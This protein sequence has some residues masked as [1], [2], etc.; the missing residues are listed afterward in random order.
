MKAKHSEAMR[1]LQEE[2]ATLVRFDNELKELEEVI[3]A[4]KQAI[5]DAELQRKRL[6]HEAQAL[7][8]DKAAS[9]N[10]VANLEKMHEWINAEKQSVLPIILRQSLLRP[11]LGFLARL[12]QSL[13]STLRI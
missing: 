1:K 10:F 2:R 11:V 9:V 3:K 8:K 13:I 7:A 6:E 4:K 5:S 12:A